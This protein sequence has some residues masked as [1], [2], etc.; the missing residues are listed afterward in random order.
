MGMFREAARH[1]YAIPFFW[2][3]VANVFE[4][5]Q[6][7]HIHIV[8]KIPAPWA[9]ALL[10]RLLDNYFR[11]GTFDFLDLA[12]GLGGMLVAV[13]VSAPIR[14]VITAPIVQWKPFFRYLR[15]SAG[16]ALFSL[17]IVTLLGQSQGDMWHPPAPP[18]SLRQVNADKPVIT[19]A[20]NDTFLAAWEQANTTLPRSSM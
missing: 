3:M 12:A 13:F 20:G 18:A 7:F 1:R 8:E 2:M 4:A 16:F 6:Y 5:G 9:D 17:G 10:V 15:I 11:F 19:I 14:G